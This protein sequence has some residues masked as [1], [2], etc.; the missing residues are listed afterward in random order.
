MWKWTSLSLGISHLLTSGDDM[1][2]GGGLGNTKKNL[3]A[4]HSQSRSEDVILCCSRQ[5]FF[6]KDESSSNYPSILPEWL[7][8]CGA[9]T[10]PEKMVFPGKTQTGHSGLVMILSS[11]ESSYC[12][13]LSSKLDLG[14]GFLEGCFCFQ[15]MVCC[16]TDSRHARIRPQSFFFFLKQG[17]IKI[18]WATA[19]LKNKPQEHSRVEPLK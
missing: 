12:W 15:G 18:L 19:A 11:P 6:L 9:L 14:K 4:Q 2:V 13:G 7:L 8:W 1:Q 17:K 3:Q 5:M 10:S 16:C